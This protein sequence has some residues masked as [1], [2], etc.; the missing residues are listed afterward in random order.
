MGKYSLRFFWCVI[1]ASLCLFPFGSAFSA[2]RTVIADRDRI[3]VMIS[4]DGLANFYMDDSA[5]EMP[6]IRKLAAEGAGAA[7]MRASDPTVTWTNHTTLVTGVSPAK[8]GVLANNYFDRLKGEKVTLIWDPVFDK[9][10]AVKVPTLY[11]LAKAAGLKTAGVRW[12]ATRNARAIDWNAPDLGKL[13]LVE[14]YTTPELI[15]ECKDAKLDIIYGNEGKTLS[16]SETIEQ[17]ETWTRVFNMILHKHRPNFGLL[18]VVAVDH[19]EHMEGPRSDGAYEAIKAADGQVR[20][21]WEELERDFPGK[22]TL[23]IVSDHGFSANRTKLSAN[24]PLEKAGLMETRGG[25]VTGGAVRIVPQGGSAFLYVM[26]EGRRDDIMRQVKKVFANVDGVAKV[27][28]P[29]EY[30]EYGIADP[31]RDPRAPDMVLEAKL[32]YYFG[33]TA[34]GLKTE[35]KG[36]HGHDSHLPELHAV[37]VAWGRGIKPGAKLGEIDNRSVAPTIAK[38]LGVEIP[39]AEGKPLTDALAE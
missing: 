33:D 29:D 36:S 30:P 11:D 24:E 20:Q 16:R 38:L 9:D 5:A 22:A 23:F 3:V 13:E 12:P 1:A 10:E 8:H 31:R 34:A 18:H 27:L 28:T 6:T 17:D 15:E 7:S 35:H 4:I 37:F 14:K 32:G 21:V 2:T 39:G 19:T 26:D 25:R